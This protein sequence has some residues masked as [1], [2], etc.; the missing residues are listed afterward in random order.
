M[1]VF[2]LFLKLVHYTIILYLLKFQNQDLQATTNYS[3][4]CLDG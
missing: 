3:G 4:L 2:R 1:Q